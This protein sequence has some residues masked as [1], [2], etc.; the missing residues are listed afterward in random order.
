MLVI[1][2]LLNI[3]AT[4]ASRCAPPKNVLCDVG[5]W[6]PITTT[7]GTW[8]LLNYTSS[9]GYPNCSL[10]LTHDG[11]QIPRMWF[12]S[13]D[14][15]TYD[16][17]YDFSAFE[18]A[19]EVTLNSQGKVGYGELGLFFRLSSW[20]DDEWGWE[21]GSGL[22]VFAQIVED[23]FIWARA[24]E[25]SGGEDITDR[26]S[27]IPINK[28]LKHKISIVVDTTNNNLYNISFDDKIFFSDLDW[29]TYDLTSG[30]MGFFSYYANITIHHMIMKDLGGPTCN[31]TSIPTLLPTIEPSFA[32]TGPSL[33]PTNS[34]SLSPSLPSF[35][36]TNSPTP[37]SFSPTNTPTLSPSLPSISPTTFPTLSPTITPTLS[38]SLPS[39]SPTNS[40]SLPPTNVP[41]F[42]PTIPPTLLPSLSPINSPTSLPTNA[43]T[44]S[45]SSD[46]TI[47][48]FARFNVSQTLFIL[49]NST[50]VQYN[51]TNLGNNVRLQSNFT[52][53]LQEQSQS[54]IGNNNNN[55]HNNDEKPIIVIEIEKIWG[56]NGTSISD[57]C[58]LK[59]SIDNIINNEYSVKYYLSWIR[60]EVKFINLDKK[61]DWLE[62]IDFIMRIFEDELEELEYFINDTI[63]VNYCYV[64]IDTADD[65]EN[66]NNS[67]QSFSMISIVCIVSVFIF[68]ALFGFIDSTFVRRNENF[69]FGAIMF[70]AMCILDFVSGAFYIM[71]LVKIISFEIS[72]FTKNAKN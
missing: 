40:P 1:V 53:L 71:S 16:T 34:P 61:E 55:N 66:T 70:A 62:E 49:F 6:S 50:M 72:T 42:F 11:H 10:V 33:S 21:K 39:L 54:N 31:P 43:P 59:N 69:S 51:A 37:P 17:T 23:G 2:F 4:S 32:P 58:E 19:A 46:P 35:S 8:T 26:R 13:S 30:S 25:P 15:N 56:Y 27:L 65:N 14:G 12:G 29:S 52:S 63:S 3:F 44:F 38:P 36:P 41:T 9:D 28:T 5:S 48:Y 45:P 67:L 20:S 57:N 22:G 68:I 18:F 7:G 47:N 60:F 64:T 24:I